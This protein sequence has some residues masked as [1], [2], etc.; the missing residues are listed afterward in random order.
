MSL[1]QNAITDGHSLPQ[2]VSQSRRAWRR[3][4]RHKTA[5]GGLVWLCLVAIATLFGPWIAPHKLVFANFIVANEAPSWQ[6]PFGTNE[7]GQDMFSMA[8]YGT[9]FS[10]SIAAGSTLIA[11][12]IG[13]IIGLAAGMSKSWLDQVL[14][15]FTDFMFAFPAFFFS[16]VLIEVFGRSL[17]AIVISIGILQWAGFARL[18]RGMVLTVRDSD[19]VES[20]LAIGASRFFIA[21]RYV[22][23]NIISSVI[24]YTAFAMVNML[25]IEAMISL[26]GFGPQPPLVDFG[27]LISM[28][29]RDVL[30]YSWL[31]YCPVGVF[32]LTLVSLVVVGEGLQSV[33]NP[34]GGR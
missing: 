34:K 11:F 8:I 30:G 12:V 24:V 23:P 27:A 25:N 19:L 33:L 5:V 2:P 26:M 13:S 22:F 17:T 3:F 21:T 4:T 28:G 10:A 32:V 16:I 15:R 31:M 14:M 6:Y 18:I 9:R 1:A 29:I 7:L 20:G